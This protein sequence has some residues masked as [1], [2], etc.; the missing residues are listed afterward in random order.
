MGA[1]AGRPIAL[2]PAAQAAAIER[3]RETSMPWYD[4]LLEQLRVYRTGT[5]EP[6][7]L[8]TWWSARL[9]EARAVAQPPRMFRSC[10]TSSG[11]SRSAPDPPYTEVPVFLAQNVD[12][13]PAALDTLRYVDYALLAR[14]ITAECCSAWA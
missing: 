14:R 8:D 12:L 3:R 11:R 4:P 1:G 10:V 5:A 9:A 2:M 6:A 7:G 13:I